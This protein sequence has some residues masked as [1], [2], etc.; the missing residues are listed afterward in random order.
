MSNENDK[1]NAA[2]QN[3]I[4]KLLDDILKNNHFA[5]AAGKVSQSDIFTENNLII[6]GP[7]IGTQE[8]YLVAG[9]IRGNTLEKLDSVLSVQGELYM[10]LQKQMPS[11]FDKNVSLLLCVKTDDKGT[12][13]QLEEN[14]RRLEQRILKLEEDPY[15]FKKLVLTYSDSEIGEIEEELGDTGE[16]MWELMQRRVGE[17]S[18]KSQKEE[19]DDKVNL[20]QE[21][22]RLIV[23]LYMKLPFLKLK[24]QS[25]DE[26]ENIKEEMQEEIKE[27]AEKH[28]WN[29]IHEL[30]VSDIEKMELKNNDT[31]DAELKKWIPGE[32]KT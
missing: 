21:I 11:A 28:I 18:V 32:E 9:N 10:E 7:D 29:L 6:Y 25:G 4:F 14:R 26:L 24:L 27:T 15:Y 30:E 13:K 20:D 22:G 8:Q 5:Q 2:D 17:A 12:K 16:T 1:Q 31:L 23:H 19:K 3:A